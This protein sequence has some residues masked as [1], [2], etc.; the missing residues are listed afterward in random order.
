MDYLAAED[1]FYFALF[2]FNIRIKIVFGIL[3]GSLLSTE[4]LGSS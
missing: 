4:G 2:F 3:A 1:L